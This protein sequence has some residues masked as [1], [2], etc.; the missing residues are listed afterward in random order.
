MD[1][2]LLLIDNTQKT[3][4]TAIELAQTAPGELRDY[5][6][7]WAAEDLYSVGDGV[8]AR[9]LRSA[10]RNLEAEYKFDPQKLN[11]YWKSV[12]THYQEK[13]AEHV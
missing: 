4:E 6:V 7:E 3:L 11:E 8:Q 13:S 10:I 9:E 2:I 1:E 12:L 5:I